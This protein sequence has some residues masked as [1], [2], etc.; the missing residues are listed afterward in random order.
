MIVWLI[1][2]RSCATSCWQDWIIHYSLVLSLPGFGS[3]GA[4]RFCFCF[5]FRYRRHPRD[6][7]E[8]KR[9][10]FVE[11]RLQKHVGRI[12]PLFAL[13]CCGAV[14]VLLVL[15]GY[16]NATMGVGRRQDKVRGS[17][18]N[19]A[20]IE[21]DRLGPVVVAAVVLWGAPLCNCPIAVAV[22]VAIAIAV[23][24][25]GGQE[26]AGLGPVGETDH[27]IVLIGGIGAL[28]NA[29]RFRAV[30]RHHD[31][32]D[33]G[34][35]GDDLWVAHLRIEGLPQ[36]DGGIVRGG[37]VFLFVFGFVIVIVAARLL[38]LGPIDLRFLPGHP[39]KMERGCLQIRN[40]L[41]V[42]GVH[43][44]ERVEVSKLGGTIDPG[45]HVLETTGTGA[46][47]VVV[48]AVA[49]VAIVVC[50]FGFGFT[51]C[52]VVTSLLC[53][54]FVFARVF[55]FVVLGTGLYFSP[56]GSTGSLTIRQTDRTVGGFVLLG[57]IVIGI[58]FWPLVVRD[59]IIHSSSNSSSYGSL[60]AKGCCCC[61]C[62][63]RGIL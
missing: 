36:G 29:R 14:V 4:V 24:L 31:R 60:L 18:Y 25:V 57:Q 33:P 35:D 43:L 50:G 46:V 13:L 27:V 34:F 21:R 44:D 63:Q 12:T 48:A 7:G 54:L 56:V 1:G 55:L 49:F 62:W 19:K 11:V 8:R 9:L 20:N 58:D 26:V 17:R 10:G 22:A 15:L 2:L 16:Y 47:V 45:H 41:R 5:R 30:V 6:V 59:I 3:D 40:P 51:G 53:L 39:A 52:F 28:E 61:C 37:F 23:A 42:V 38:P 32:G